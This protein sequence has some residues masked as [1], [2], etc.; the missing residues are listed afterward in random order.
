MASTKAYSVIRLFNHILVILQLVT[1]VGLFALLFYSYQAFTI[2]THSN[3]RGFNLTKVMILIGFINF[4][5]PFF[6]AC[7]IDSRL[8][9]YMKLFSVFIVLN[10]ILNGFILLFCKYKLLK[11]FQ[12]DFSI[13]E[14][15]DSAGMSFIKAQFN[16]TAVSTPNC[17]QKCSDIIQ[18]SNTFIQYLIIAFMVVNLLMAILVKVTLGVKLVKP[19]HV[20]PK[21]I[22]PQV[23][24]ST[25]SLR[26]RK[27][28]INSPADHHID[29][30]QDELQFS[31]HMPHESNVENGP[32]ISPERN[33]EESI[34]RN[35]ERS[36]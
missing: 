24:F 9:L 11:N 33:P 35:P 3:F 32:E 7:A 5:V 6:G 12:E 28:Y 31:E 1:V 25:D 27:L 4:I 10:L 2:E 8:R 22:R 34:E 15:N 21:I 29:I 30:I 14:T 16:C 20:R 26:K 36:S 19:K 13:T 17:M 23:G 18:Q